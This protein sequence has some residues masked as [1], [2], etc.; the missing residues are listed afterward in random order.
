RF[1]LNVPSEDLESFERILFL[2]EQAHWFYE[3]NAVEQDSA[4]K[5][6]SLRE[7]TSL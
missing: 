7:F 2:V 5:S 6:L 1:V 3:D 4:L